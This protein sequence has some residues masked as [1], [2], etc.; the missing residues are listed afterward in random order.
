LANSSSRAHRLA[1]IA[2]LL[3]IVTFAVGIGFI[4]IAIGHDA[5]GS[6][7]C[8]SVNK[9]CLTTTTDPCILPPGTNPNQCHLYTW[10]N[11]PARVDNYAVTGLFNN[12]TSYNFQLNSTNIIAYDMC[13]NVR[14]ISTGSAVLLPQIFTGG[15][16]ADLHGSFLAT[17]LGG[18][19]LSATGLQCSGYQT[20]NATIPHT[21]ENRFR[22]AGEFGGGA[23]D[24]PQFSELMLQVFYS[25]TITTTAQTSTANIACTPTIVSTS[26]FVYRCSVGVGLTTASVSMT[27]NWEANNLGVGFQGGTGACTI[28]IS[29]STCTQTLS[30][31]PVFAVAPTVDISLWTPYSTTVTLPAPSFTVPQPS[32]PVMILP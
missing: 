3:D 13:V 30:F 24:N 6:L 1:V 23:G 22:I 31:S 10:K 28:P 2:I 32:A 25:N 29:G 16:F 7:E 11:F 27:I 5:G 20:V 21:G 26:Q 8:T 15:Q 9:L 12:D 17:T 4:F 18:I 19:A 14:T